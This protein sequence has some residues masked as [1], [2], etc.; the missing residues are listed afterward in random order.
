ML[1]IAYLYGFDL[2]KP[3]HSYWTFERFI[4]NTPNQYFSNIMQNLVLLVKDLGFIDNSFVSADA[5][6]VFANTKFN[7]PKSFTDITCHF[8]FSN[9]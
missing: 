5:T 1:Y 3:L 8:C 7:N 6:P 4:K 2:F 9:Q